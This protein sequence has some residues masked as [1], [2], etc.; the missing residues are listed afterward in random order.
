MRRG[1]FW[2]EVPR[3]EDDHSV[4]L[5]SFGAWYNANLK[6][7]ECSRD[8]KPNLASPADVRMCVASANPGANCSRLAPSEIDG[9]E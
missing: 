2:R 1:R 3:R 8:R 4:L 5:I 6:H 7:L 9:S